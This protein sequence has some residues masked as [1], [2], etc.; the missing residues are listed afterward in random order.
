[1][2]LPSGLKK[3]GNAVFINCRRLE[4]IV[5]PDCKT[6]LGPLDFQ[7]CFSL[8][9]IEIPESVTK[10]DETAFQGLTADDGIITIYGKEGSYAQTY[11]LEHPELFTFIVK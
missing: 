4:S 2:E 6:E 1:M 10:I 5:I 9:S 3:M 11:A 8:K 7:Y